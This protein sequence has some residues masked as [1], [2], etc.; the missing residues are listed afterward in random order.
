[1]RLPK[2]LQDEADA[3]EAAMRSPKSRGQV[4]AKGP[5]MLPLDT[6]CLR[7]GA[8]IVAGMRVYLNRGDRVFYYK[9]RYLLN[10]VK[11][12]KGEE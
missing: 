5:P 1:M 3:L 10:G 8:Y 11:P 4:L 6:P 7:V 12:L 2:K 9:G